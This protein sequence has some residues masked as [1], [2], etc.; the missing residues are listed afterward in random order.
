MHELTSPNCKKHNDKLE[1]IPEDIFNKRLNFDT[2]GCNCDLY[3]DYKMPDDFLCCIDCC[4]EC[5]EWRE[6]MIKEKLNNY[7]HPT[8]KKHG[9]S[10][11]EMPHD[12]LLQRQNEQFEDCTMYCNDVFYIDYRMPKDE[13]CCDQCCVEC[14]EWRKRRP[15][16]L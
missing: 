10:L 16:V 12:I 2:D 14:F 6:N 15:S 8:C 13:Y 5:K 3:D 1:I 11:P 7:T 9:I 4:N